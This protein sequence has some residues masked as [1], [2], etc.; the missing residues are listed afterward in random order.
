MNSINA[1]EHITGIKV[2]EVSIVKSNPLHN[3]PSNALICIDKGENNKQMYILHMF[4]LTPAMVEPKNK[5]IESLPKPGIDNI[6]EIM[7]HWKPLSHI[8]AD[9]VYID[10][11]E[12]KIKGERK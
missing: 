10:K 1:V 5:Y 9:L 3:D 2:S 8:M 12:L 11:V 7:Y 6:K 4:K